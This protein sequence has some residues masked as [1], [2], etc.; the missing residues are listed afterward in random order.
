MKVSISKYLDGPDIDERELCN[1][2]I[3]ACAPK[4]IEAKQTIAALVAEEW[5]ANLLDD[6]TRVILIQQQLEKWRE[7]YHTMLEEWDNMRLR[8]EEL[9]EEGILDSESD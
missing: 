4:I 2:G 7:V 9:D 1:L 6:P 8:L 5:K 3:G